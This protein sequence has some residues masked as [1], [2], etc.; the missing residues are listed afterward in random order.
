MYNTQYYILIFKSSSHRIILFN[1]LKEKNILAELIPTPC[2]LGKGCSKA[3]K[4]DEKDFDKVYKIIKED[5][6]IIKEIYKKIIT[7]PSFYYKKIER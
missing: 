3:I 2:T 7:G 5:N 1:K 4:I 6:I